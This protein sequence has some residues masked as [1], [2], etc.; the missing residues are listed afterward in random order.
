MFGIKNDIRRAMARFGLSRE[1][2]AFM[3]CK[4]TQ[5]EMEKVC[6]NK[7]FCPEVIKFVKITHTVEVKLK[8]FVIGQQ[9]R[10]KNA[11]IINC[12]NEKMGGV[13]VEKIRY[14]MG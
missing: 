3:V 1:L 6:K 9:I 14:R 11:Q 10:S 4:I 5:Q 8:N 7:M 12:V 13:Y 2:D